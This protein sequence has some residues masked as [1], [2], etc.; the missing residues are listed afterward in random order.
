MIPNGLIN[1]G[2][3]CYLNSALQVLYSI[4][5]LRKYLLSG[6]YIK[7]IA[8]DNKLGHQGK[9]INTLASF[10]KSYETNSPDITPLLHLLS[11]NFR[12]GEQH[13]SHEVLTYLLDN[14][15]E[16]VNTKGSVIS[17]IFYGKLGSCI[18]CEHCDYTSHNKNI[19]GGLQLDI[20]NWSEYLF[21]VSKVSLINSVIVG[22][23]GIVNGKCIG[24][25]VF[26]CTRR[27]MSSNDLIIVVANQLKINPENI[28]RL[29]ITRNG[30][31]RQIFDSEF[32]LLEKSTIEVDAE[33]IYLQL[34][35]D[36]TMSISDSIKQYFTSEVL[37]EW[38]C[39]KCLSFGG[40]RIAVIDD[41]PQ[42]LIV[43][44]KLFELGYYG[45]VKKK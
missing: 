38:K 26:I 14:I 16:D 39:E 4:V 33:K 37:D 10:F 29:F 32:V 7:D 20:P 34:L 6:E 17:D 30:L 27:Y 31:K 1:Q 42:Y 23:K 36:K 8:I 28:N 22:L 9:F 24:S 2:N 45:Y 25:K 13:D 5:P 35:S 40:R 41:L 43:N 18:S 12:F 44:I 15:H 11:S 21:D 19:I 3:I